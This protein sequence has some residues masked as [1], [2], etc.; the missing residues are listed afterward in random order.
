MLI[1]KMIFILHEKTIFVGLRYVYG[2]GSKSLISLKLGL[3]GL[4]GPLMPNITLVLYRSVIFSGY[5]GYTVGGQNLKVRGNFAQ[6]GY[7]TC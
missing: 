5:G 1:T 4:F 6:R 7:W 2:R 3:G